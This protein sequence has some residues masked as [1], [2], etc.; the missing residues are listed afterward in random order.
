MIREEFPNVRLD[1][2]EQSRGYIVH[3]NRAADLVSSAILVSIDDD[4]AFSSPHTVQQTISEFDLPRVGA[5]SIPSVDV[6]QPGQPFFHQGPP[7]DAVWVVEAYRGTAYAIRRD[8]FTKLGGY[9][10]SFFHQGEEGEY[11]IRMLN[12]GYVTRL[13]AASP[14][15]HFESPKRDRSRMFIHDARNRVLF[16]WYNVPLPDLLVHLPATMLRAIRHGSKHHY[17][18]AASRGVMFGIG[19]IFK[20]LNQRRPVSRQVYRLSRQLRKQ[21]P[22]KLEAIES[23]L[24]ELPQCCPGTDA[25]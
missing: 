15:H 19:M 25:E 20:Q 17:A 4:A 3:R 22:V 21:G 9:K 14:I 12:A 6:N 8:L 11:C 13:G 5:V 10:V 7:D 1:R 24:P 2:V 18:W 16:A 23:S